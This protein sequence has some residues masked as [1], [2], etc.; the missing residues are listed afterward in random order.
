MGSRDRG[1]E[2]SRIILFHRSIQFQLFCQQLRGT[3]NDVEY[4]ALV[5][6]HL[7]FY[8]KVQSEIWRDYIVVFPGIRELLEKLHKKGVKMAIVT[9]R[10]KFV[11]LI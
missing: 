9:S 3:L 5:E 2:G 10:T 8:R 4:D 11:F 7:A 1:I 6:T